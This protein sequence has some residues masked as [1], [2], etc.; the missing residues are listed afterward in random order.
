MM[1]AVVM[2]P[3]CARLMPV[4][5]TLTESRTRT[6]GWIGAEASAPA[7]TGDVAVGVD[8]ARHDRLAGQVVRLGAGGH[9]DR[10]AHGD[11]LA[12]PDDQ[13]ALLDG[14]PADGD[15]ACVGE[16][17]GGLRLDPARAQ[18]RT[19]RAARMNV[20]SMWQV[21][22]LRDSMDQLVRILNSSSGAASRASRARTRSSFIPRLVR[23]IHG[24]DCARTDTPSLAL[25]APM[26]LGD[27]GGGL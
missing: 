15:D 27:L 22:T 23:L 17:V 5:L 3:A 6:S 4:D 9:R 7:R 20:F 1:L 18:R 10:R 12:V 13:R 19:G 11:D 16:G 14:G 26:L 24:S 25:P 2:P 21:L 8:Q